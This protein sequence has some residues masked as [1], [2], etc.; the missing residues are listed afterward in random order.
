MGKNCLLWFFPFQCKKK[1]NEL[2]GLEF[3]VNARYKKEYLDD[4]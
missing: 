4:N 2:D 3:G 1:R